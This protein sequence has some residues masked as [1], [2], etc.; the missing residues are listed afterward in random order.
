MDSEHLHC[1]RLAVG[2]SLGEAGVCAVGREC[3]TV[4]VTWLSHAY[5]AHANLGEDF[6]RVFA[7][8]ERKSLR[9]FLGTGLSHHGRHA[10]PP[11]TTREGLHQ[12]NPRA[13]RLLAT[14][15]VSVGD[16]EFM[17]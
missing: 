4:D 2:A 7:D 12:T 3:A 14:Q 5:Y 10:T 15:K 9:R 11:T 17:F 6:C 16:L 13:T 1:L 8:E